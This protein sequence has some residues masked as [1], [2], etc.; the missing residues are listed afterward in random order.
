M[1][2]SERQRGMIFPLWLLTDDLGT[3]ELFATLADCLVAQTDLMTHGIKA[4]VRLLEVTG[5]RSPTIH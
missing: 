4:I 5:N 3:S 1:L 2:L